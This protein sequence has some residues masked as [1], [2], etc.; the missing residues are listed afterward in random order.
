LAEKFEQNYPNLFDIY[1]ERNIEV[2][3]DEIKDDN[4][5][6]LAYNFD[7]TISDMKLAGLKVYLRQEWHSKPI[8]L[9]HALTWFAEKRLNSNEKLKFQSNKLT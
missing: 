9:I 7:G 3:V 6:N 8:Q 1:T 2:E 5:E 4:E